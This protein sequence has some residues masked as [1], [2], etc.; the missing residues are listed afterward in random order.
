V[1]CDLCGCI[2]VFVFE[3]DKE[4]KGTCFDIVLACKGGLHIRFIG[5]AFRMIAL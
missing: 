5:C 3:T 4:G 1:F 2:F